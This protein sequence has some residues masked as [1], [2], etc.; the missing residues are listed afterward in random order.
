LKAHLNLVEKGEDLDGNDPGTISLDQATF[1]RDLIKET[2]SNEKTFLELI[3]GVDSIEAI[4][5]RDYKRVMNALET[6]KRAKR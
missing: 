2:G 5:A 6:K 3:A 4:Q 1:I